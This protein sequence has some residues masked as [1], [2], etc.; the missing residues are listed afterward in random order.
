M[1]NFELPAENTLYNNWVEE[2]TFSSEFLVIKNLS[3][4]GQFYNLKLKLY[5]YC[6]FDIFL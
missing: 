3:C 6:F 1:Y 4:W 5:V 2:K